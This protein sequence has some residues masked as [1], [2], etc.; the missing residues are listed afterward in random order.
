MTKR[1]LFAVLGF[2][3]VLAASSESYTVVLKNGK[4]MNGTLVSENDSLIVFKDAHGLQFSI[5]KLNV[6]LDKTKQANEPPAPPVAPVAATPSAASKKDAKV[7]GQNDL[8]ALR[9]KYGDLSPGQVTIDGEMTGDSYYKTLQAGLTEA[10]DILATFKNLALDVSATWEAAISTG[11]SGHQQLSEY[12][13]TGAGFGTLSDTTTR[14]NGLQK[15]KQQ[16]MKAPKGYESVPQNF[17]ILVDSLN[18]VVNLF[19]TYNSIKDGVYFRTNIDRMNLQVTRALA[20]LESVKE[21]EEP[22]PQIE[23]TP[24]TTPPAKQEKTEPEPQKPPDI[25]N[26][27]PPTPP[28]SHS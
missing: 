28:S 10:N 20:P 1:L 24:Q 13:S 27:A 2:I 11:K 19:G 22:E 21:V 3:L 17:S 25:M 8:E 26:Q 16:L 12:M 5:K 9:T 15:V 23:A 7:Y 14:V 4:T 18:N 6:D